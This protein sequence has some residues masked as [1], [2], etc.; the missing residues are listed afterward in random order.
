MPE[1]ASPPNGTLDC[2]I[3]GGG[4]AGL[5]AATYLARYRRRV[6]VVDEGDSRA[7]WIPNSHN[8]PGFSGISG[9]ELL[10][11]LRDQAESYGAGYRRERITAV[12]PAEDHSFIA[13][14]GGRSFRA[15][16]V[17]LATGIVD[18][19]PDEPGIRD[20]VRTGTLRYCPICDAYEAMDQRIGVLGSLDSAG[21][22]A[23]F[24]RTYSA[25]VVLLLTREPGPDDEGKVA[26]LRQ[27]GVEIAP[28]VVRDLEKRGETMIALL[29]NG[30]RLEVE[31]LYPALGCHVRSELV[32]PLGA[33]CDENGC[34]IVDQKQGTG[35]PGLYAAGDVVSDLHQIAVAFG[36]AAIAATS[37][38]NALPYNFR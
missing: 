37:I 30:E 33:R 4:P 24:L 32:A 6:M 15:R 21:G 9:K 35:I 28:G 2:L 12:E 3:I 38:H 36:H 26:S 10:T 16:S 14:A 7:A 25:N 22:K 20:A 27:A 23:M 18:N 1:N 13:R 34:L 8:Y 17:L 11:L 31:V 19:D 29:S 5:T